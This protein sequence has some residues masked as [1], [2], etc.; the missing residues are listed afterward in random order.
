MAALTARPRANACTSATDRRGMPPLVYDG[1]LHREWRQRVS[2]LEGY[3]MP[4]AESEIWSAAE[5]GLVSEEILDDF[6]HME[7]RP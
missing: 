7:K 5:L 6:T 4:R 3:G 2:I 1:P